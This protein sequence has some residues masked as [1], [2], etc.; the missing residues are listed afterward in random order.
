MKIIKIMLVLG[1][2]IQGLYAEQS[3][4]QAEQQVQQPVAQAAQ[5]AAP[6]G[7]KRFAYMI[8]ACK[9]TGDLTLAEIKGALPFASEFKNRFV[10]K[11]S[12]LMY[13]GNNQPLVCKKIIA[14]NDAKMIDAPKKNEDSTDK[15]LQEPNIYTAFNSVLQALPVGTE[16]AMP[17]SAKTLLELVVVCGPNITKDQAMA[18]VPGATFVS[19]PP[20]TVSTGETCRL[21][22]VKPQVNFQGSSLAALQAVRAYLNCSSG[23][24]CPMVW[25]N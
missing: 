7:L 22:A 18:Q 6:A 10:D 2:V 9:Q 15:L 4:Q 24:A 3:P 16:S 12:T 21:V 11:V 13:P 1:C 14:W 20:F 19:D 25:G 23:F 17:T 5:V 8:F